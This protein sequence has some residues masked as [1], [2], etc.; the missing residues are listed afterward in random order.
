MLDINLIRKNNETVRKS[1]MDRRYEFDLDALLHL[2]ERRR[3]LI[4]ESESLQAKRKS[5]SKDIGLMM[6]G[7]RKEEAER[8]K[9]ETKE[10]GEQLKE[11]ESE[12]RSVQAEFDQLMLEVPN[13]PHES[14]PV[15]RS[16]DDNEE[17]RRWGEQRAFDFEIRDHVELGQNLGLLDLERGAKVTGARFYFMTGAGARLERA[18]INFMLDLHTREHGCREI[19]PPFIINTESL[20]GTGQLPK[21]EEDLFKL[22]DE[23]GLYLCPTAEV[24]VTNFFAD[25]IIDGSELPVAFAAYTPCFRSE[26]GSYGIDTRG[27]IRVHQFNKVEMVRFCRE[28]ESYEQLELL[29]SHAE[30]V[31]Q[32]LELPYRVITLCT[33]DLGFGASKTYDLE[34][35]VPSQ[36]R[37]REISSCSNYETFQARRARIRYR[38]EPGGK[39]TFAH[40]LNGS[41]LAIGRTVVALLENGQQPDGSVRLPEALA[42][43]MDGIREF[44]PQ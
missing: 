10:M 41:G 12:L 40:T 8:I 5:L 11:M 33:G 2:D 17:V 25:E 39:P 42:P 23:R 13:I 4:S 16:E 30:K 28:E 19:V 27:L 15:G 37:Y 21:F 9:A 1:L 31:L 44:T 32:L 35:W 7:G 26:A 18:L 38:P 6:K 3:S 20:I 36:D 29:T 22:T 14:V 24:P 43:Y 34:V